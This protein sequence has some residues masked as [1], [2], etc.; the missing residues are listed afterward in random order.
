MTLTAKQALHAK[1]GRHSDGK[2]LYL[3]VQ[4]SGSRSWVLRVQH[5]GRRRDLGLG[6]FIAESIN[7]AVPI[8]RRKALTL[9]QAREKARMAREIAKAG[10]NPTALWRVKEDAIPTFRET[11]EE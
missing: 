10:M 3:L 4:P 5:N 9:A 8:E 7:V 2:G 11:A 1:P 6:S